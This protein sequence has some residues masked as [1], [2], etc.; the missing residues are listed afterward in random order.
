MNK[1]QRDW[2]LT[3]TIGDLSVRLDYDIR[4]IWMAGYSDEQINGVLIGEYTLAELWEMAPLGNDRTPSGQEI[5][6]GKY[7]RK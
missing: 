4:D 3:G 6:A 5:L 2:A 7:K 1:K